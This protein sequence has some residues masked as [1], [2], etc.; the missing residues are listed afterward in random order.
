[1]RKGSVGCISTIHRVCEVNSG[2]WTYAV[3]VAAAPVRGSSSIGSVGVVGSSRSSSCGRSGLLSD[4]KGAE[5]EDGS[6][7]SELHFD[8]WIKNVWS[9]LTGTKNVLID[10]IGWTM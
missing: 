5:A 4:S 10:G 2:S 8:C 3:A 6:G 9:W 7:E 1:M